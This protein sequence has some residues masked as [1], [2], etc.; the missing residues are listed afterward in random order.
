MK[1][2]AHLLLL[3]LG[4]CIFAVP[5][6]A[7]HHRTS[8]LKPPPPEPPPLQTEAVPK[9][10]PDAPPSE[11]LQSFLNSHL[12]KVLTPL[13]VAAFAQ[14]ELV[15]ALKAAYADAAAAA[16][17]SHRPALQYA[18]AVC[19]ALANAMEERQSA[20]NALHGSLATRSDEAAQPRGGRREVRTKIRLN[21]AFF[22]T[23]QQNNWNAR[24][25]A[26]RH[27]ITALYLHERDAERQVGLWNAP[28][29]TPTATIAATSL[30]VEPPSKTPAPDARETDTPEAPNVPDATP[31]TI[32]G[33]WLW[34]GKWPIDVEPNHQVNASSR[35]GTWKE[36]V[37]PDGSR[38][39]VLR[40]AH[41]GWVNTITLAPDGKTLDGHNTGG[42]HVFA[43]RQ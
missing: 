26:L 11:S 18:Q 38:A 14:P 15:E 32:V 20:V 2:S 4:L 25:G 24:A 3:A 6:Q 41:H 27:R 42:E 13:G 12:A 29:P 34:Q 9:I 1:H 39:Y 36:V 33:R 40:W 16:P 31:A 19:E 8:A 23:S 43:Q 35:H 37:S 28:R 5:A 30:S 22:V 17:E 21:D 7:R 10:S